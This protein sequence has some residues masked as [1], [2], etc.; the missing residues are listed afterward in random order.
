MPVLAAFA[1]LAAAGCEPRLPR[2]DD[3]ADPEVAA[4]IDEA[5]A[6][7]D[8]FLAALANRTPSQAHFSLR[9]WLVSNDSEGDAEPVRELA[10]LDDVRWDGIRFRGRLNREPA[11]VKEYAR[12]DE[13]RVTRGAV[14]DWLY[15][16]SDRAVGGWTIRLLR[17]RM[18]AG[19]RE[20]FDE[21]TPYT[22]E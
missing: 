12:G 16:D 6:T 1:L 4:A 15:I 19:Q 14:A 22:F 13:V 7:L 20:K 9:V 2:A 18:T 21:V 5:Q 3:P 8:D 10:W 11:I 17:K